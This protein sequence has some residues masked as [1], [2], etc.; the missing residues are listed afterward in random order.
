MAHSE[1]MMPAEK[2]VVRLARS[3]AMPR[4]AGKN[5]TAGHSFENR[6]T[7]HNRLE[8]VANEKMA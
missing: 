4:I 8:S 2:S 1:R 6:T 3:I 7:N 5:G